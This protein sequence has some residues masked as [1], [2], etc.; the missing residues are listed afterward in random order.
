MLTAIFTSI[1]TIISKIGL[2]NVDS[3]LATFIRTI[4]VLVIM[5]FVLLFKN[6]YMCT[7]ISISDKNYSLTKNEVITFVLKI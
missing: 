3:S 5:I 1:T 7:Y 2:K 6:S 4:V